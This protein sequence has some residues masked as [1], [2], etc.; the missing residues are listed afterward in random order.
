MYEWIIK[1]NNIAFNTFLM[2]WGNSLKMTNN[3][4]L[5]YRECDSEELFNNLKE[6]HETRNGAEIT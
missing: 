4:F 5:Y 3:K 6:C 1:S 2:N